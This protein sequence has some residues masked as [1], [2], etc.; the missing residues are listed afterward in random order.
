MNTRLSGSAIVDQTPDASENLINSCID[1]R[2]LY[3][4]RFV[5]T[6][7]HTPTAA[8]APV[9]IMDDPAVFIGICLDHASVD[10]VES[11]AVLALLRVYGNL[12]PLYPDNR[13]HRL[14]WEIFGR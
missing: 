12:H 2:H 1:V 9:S 14:F 6:Y 3:G 4:N 5:R 8:F 11:P 7:G 13:V 10:A